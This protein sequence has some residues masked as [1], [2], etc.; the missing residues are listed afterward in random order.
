MQCVLMDTLDSRGFGLF[1]IGVF[2]VSITVLSFEVALA[3]QFAF[4]FW[5][6]LSFIVIAVAMFGIGVGSVLGYFIKLKYRDSYFSILHWSSLGIGGGMLLFLLATATASRTASFQYPGSGSLAGFIL[7]L[8]IALGS[9]AVPFLF[10]GVFLSVAFDYPSPRKRMISFIYFADLI[11]AGIGASLITTLLPFSSVEGLIAV[12]ALIVFLS[13]IIFLEKP[14][15][16]DAAVVLVLVFFAAGVFMNAASFSPES[17]G[18]KFLSAAKEHGVSVLDTHWTPVSRIDVIEY[19]D[20][21]LRRFVENAEYPITISDGNMDGGRDADPRWAMFIGAPRSML[22]IGSGGGVELTMALKEGVEQIHAV[23]INPF[24]I[25]YMKNEMAVFSRR[26]YYNPSIRTEIEDGRTF[27][28]RSDEKYDLIENGVLGSAG[29]VVPTTAMLTTKDMSVYTVRAN[30][31]YIRH[32][33]PEGVSVTIIYGLLDDYNLIDGESGV[34]AM[35]LKQYR[36]VSTALEREDMDPSRHIIMMRYVQRAGNFQDSL[37]QAEYTFIF[38]SELDR[39]MAQ[40]WIDEAEKYGLEVVYSPF[41]EGSLDLEA[42]I[43]GLHGSRDISPTTDDRPFFYFTDRSI[44]YIL[45]PVTAAMLLLILLFIIM[46]IARHQKM[47]FERKNLA[48]LAFFLSIGVGY[49]LVEATLIQKLVLFLGRPAHAFQVVLA[50]MLIFSGL[51]SMTTGLV[52]KKEEHEPRIV[53][54]LALTIAILVILY[55]VLVQSFIM[56]YIHLELTTKILLTIAFLAPPAFIMGMP[57]P[58]GL[59]LVGRKDPQNII[60]MYGLNS[61]GSVVAS[62]LGMFMALMY[63]FSSSLCLGGLMYIAALVSISYIEEER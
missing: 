36:T 4:M 1:L 24:I 34:T 23:E 54:R 3:F 35:L 40:R 5:F 16:R 46:P 21:G 17:M 28:H 2:L 26:L 56:Q 47:I 41:Y 51:G 43:S 8:S 9:S 45:L 33:T 30:Q 31:E 60:W 25:R 44:G 62:M 50:S 32:L 59:R 18:G 42:V 49:I 55:S 13:S 37:A 48:M 27:V 19:S 20:T 57:F 52:F 10:S 12:G 38:K 53:A 39:G 63:G 11:G 22:A 29:L 61:S 14:G 6:Y 58:M 7:S 15:L